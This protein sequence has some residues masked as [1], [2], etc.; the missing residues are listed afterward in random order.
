MKNNKPILSIKH[1]SYHTAMLK[2]TNMRSE[3]L[4]STLGRE[5]FM[6][7]VAGVAPEKPPFYH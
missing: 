2:K 6:P 4:V 1:A 3:M 7:F 5:K